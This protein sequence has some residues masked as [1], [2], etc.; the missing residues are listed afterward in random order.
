MTEQTQVKNA[1]S[2]LIRLGF[3]DLNNRYEARTAVFR[4]ECVFST[5][6]VGG[7]PAD[8]EGIRQF[9]IHHLGIT[10]PDEVQAAVDRIQ[11]EELQDVTPPEGEI[12]EEKVY[13]VR[14]L[15]RDST[16]VF[17]GNW[18][19]KAC[20]KVA[21]SRLGIFQEKR[22]SKGDV[23]EVGRVQAWKYSLKDKTKPF[24]IYCIGPDAEDQPP[25]TYHKD[26]MGRVSTPTGPVS[27][28]HK[29]E[30]LAPG[31]RFAFEFRFLQNFLDEDDIQDVLAFMMT[32]G[33]GSARSL[34]RGKF[35]IENAE[36]ELGEVKRKPAKKEKGEKGK[37]AEGEKPEDG[38]EQAQTA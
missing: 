32:I 25:K 36:L 14:S 9:V 33:L 38:Q 5:E 18:M 29:S 26:F 31:T 15:R 16:G 24:Q 4:A 35:R 21:M 10:N 37:K 8:E 30:C 17:L 3:D 7:Q 28:I 1:K 19:A 34:E 13:G 20:V 23:A 6:C 22:G 12:K 27:I 2:K 11:N